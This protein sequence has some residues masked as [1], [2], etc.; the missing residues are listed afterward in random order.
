MTPEARIKKSIVAYLDS[1]GEKCWH[2]A[3]HNM[4]YGAYG[5]PDRLCCYR[6]V[7]FAPEVKRKNGKA[8]KR[9]QTQH[10]AI[11]AAGGIAE[12]VDDVKQVKEIIAR[13]DA[14]FE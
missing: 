4:G 7:F 6:G 12:V 8:R 9:Q 14:M 10:E 2:V 13:I 1:L 3:Y 5:V 11:I